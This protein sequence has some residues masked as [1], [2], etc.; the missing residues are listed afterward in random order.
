MG[1]GALTWDVVT[2]HTAVSEA[3]GN[4]GEASPWTHDSQVPRGE[5]E[6]LR[7]EELCSQD[8]DVDSCQQGP[9]GF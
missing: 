9:C 8:L 3:M 2:T 4:S 6:P 7:Q 1:I 5:A